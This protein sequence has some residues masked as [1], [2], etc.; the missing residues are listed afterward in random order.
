MI[1]LLKPSQWTNLGYIILGIVLAPYTNWLTL[2]VPVWMMIETSFTRYEIY[3]DRIIYRRGVFTVTT[4]EIL[5]YRIKAINLNE[6]FLYRLVGISNLSIIT[7]DKY[8]NEITL[9]GVPVGM[10]FR[11]ALRELVEENRTK[12][13]VKEFDLY[14]LSV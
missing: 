7:S 11:N 5:L 8:V 4:D 6:P 13:G 10:N 12:K 2:V 14:E 3:D 1:T 9:K